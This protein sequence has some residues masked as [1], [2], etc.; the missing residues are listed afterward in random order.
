MRIVEES[1][2]WIFILAKHYRKEETD[3]TNSKEAIFQVKESVR[4]RVTNFCPL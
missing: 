3:V 4:G 2:K 1:K